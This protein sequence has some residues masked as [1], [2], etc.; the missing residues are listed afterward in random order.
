M[1]FL[2]QLWLL[3]PHFSKGDGQLISKK[4]LKCVRSTYRLVLKP[5]RDFLPFWVKWPFTRGCIVSFHLSTSGESRSLH[6][7]LY[8]LLELAHT[9]SDQSTEKKGVLRYLQSCNLQQQVEC[10][11]ENDGASAGCLTI[12]HQSILIVSANIAYRNKCPV[13]WIMLSKLKEWQ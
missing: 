5:I 10:G 9:F 7:S 2:L 3:L 13:S 12:T 6:C 4:A 1:T 11:I 8:W